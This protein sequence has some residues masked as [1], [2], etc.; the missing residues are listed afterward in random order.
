MHNIRL[1]EEYPPADEPADIRKMVALID[2]LH[3]PQNDGR[4]LRAQHAKDTG[5]VKALLTV[6]PGLSPEFC[7]GVFREPR[8]YPVIIRFSNASD[9]VMSD[10]SGTPRGM[11]IK[12]LQV[13]GERA[14]DGD[15]ESSQDFLLVDSPAF[16]F[17]AVKDYTILFALRQR[18]RFDMLAILAYFFIYPSQTLRLIKSSRNKI[19][20]S[21][22]RQYWSM[23]PFRLGPRAVK[24]SAKP[25]DANVS[26]AS[27]EGAESDF[28]F[29]VA[30]LAD[31]LKANDA[32]FDFMVQFQEDP[33]SMPI[34]DA[35]VEWNESRSPFRKVATI[36]IPAQDLE[37]PEMMEFRN[38]CEVLS[39]N[40]W[41]ALADHRPLGGL[42]RLRRGAYEMSVRRRLRK[43]S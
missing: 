17:S 22:I 39:F 30:R 41:H 1:N 23:S 2:A 20:N 38:S 33:V 11:A 12:I 40:P 21:L 31:S 7:F 18:L 10:S 6:L 28:N 36:R 29:L 24:F 15:G 19:N 9:S 27:E 42:N 5:C 43:P 26:T 35:S 37:S 16:I 13:E 25:Q 4:V 14:I 8:T 3:H 34:E 32:S